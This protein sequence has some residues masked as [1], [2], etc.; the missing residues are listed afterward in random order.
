MKEQ[1]VQTALNRGFRL[2]MIGGSDVH[3]ARTLR[4]N[5]LRSRYMHPGGF[6]GVWAPE[7]SR[8]AVWNALWNRRC[9]ATTGRRI[10]LDFSV[11]RQPMGAEVVLND[12][13]ADFSS[14]RINALV[15]GAEELSRVT[16]VRNGEDLFTE[17]NP[18]DNEFE[19]EDT[20]SLAAVALKSSWKHI[21]RH[22]EYSR[23]F[24]YYYLRVLQK[25]GEMAWSSP[26]WLL[27]ASS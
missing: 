8:E 5:W 25:D 14:R 18:K 7:L 2:G 6:M 23:P 24:V 16:L 10:I 22:P 13:A 19:W 15:I 26:I 12:E 1:S 9:Y 4:R 11:N 17:E 21:G 27:S 20:D 3:A